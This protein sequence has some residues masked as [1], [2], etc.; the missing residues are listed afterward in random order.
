MNELL[1]KSVSI[2]WIFVLLLTD[3]ITNSKPTTNF[4][5]PFLPDNEK[6]QIHTDTQHFFF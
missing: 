1:T 6:I 4:L 5:K 2:F 3:L